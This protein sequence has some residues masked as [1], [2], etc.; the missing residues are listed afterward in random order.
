[1]N[2]ESA[3]SC[4]EETTL[5]TCQQYQALLAVA[6]A[7]VAHRDLNAL[8]HDL[9]VHLRE[10]VRFDVLCLVRHDAENNLMH[11]HVFDYAG[12]LPA[13]AP[14]AFPVEDDPGGQVLHSQQPLIFSTMPEAAPCPRYLD[15]ID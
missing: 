1:M 2:D 6:E 9:A 12:P 10:V 7:I 15:D 14:A 3:K 4:S 11:R 13:D 5:A 8:I